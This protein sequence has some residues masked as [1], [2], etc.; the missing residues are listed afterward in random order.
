MPVHNVRAYLRACLDSILGQ[1]F[2]D[3]EIIA[4]DDASPDGSGEI[5]DVY[6][7]MDSRIHVTHLAHN[8]GLGPARDAGVEQAQ[9]SYLLFVDSDDELT[10]GAL[11]AIAERVDETR[12]PDVLI[13]DY[14]RTYWTGR[15]SRNLLAD[16]L[17]NAGDGVFRAE[18]HPELLELLMVVWNKAYKREYVGA[19]GFRFPTGYYEDLPWT[20]PTML[21]AHTIA[22]LDRVCYHYRQRRHGNILRSQNR[23]HFDVFD[24]YDLVLGFLDSHH[25][26]ES[27]RPFLFRRMLD[28]IL[29]IMGSEDRIPAS[30]R[31]EFFDRLAVQYRTHKPPGYQLPGGPR[32]VKLRAV[33]HDDYAMFEAARLGGRIV[34]RGKVRAAKTR[35]ATK[36]GWIASKRKLIRAAY[37]AELRKPVDENLAV[38]AAYWYA[39]YGCNPGAIYEEAKRLAPHIRGVWVVKKSRV[40]V[41]PEGVDYVEVDS[42]AYYRLMA[43]AKYFVN[44]VNFRDNIVKRPGTVHVQ[45]QHGTPLK[46]MG[47]D[48]REFPVGAAGMSF[49]KLLERCDRWDFLVSS[50]R[51]STQVWERSYPCAYITLETGYP[52]NDR[53]VRATAEETAE[54]RRK[55]ELP[56]DKT[57]LLYTPTFRD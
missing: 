9:G 47:L 30:L 4:V 51:F 48:L 25:E 42:P 56:L 12:Q 10:P 41:M 31:R 13:F 38:Y 55:L 20:Y 50:N 15:V 57:V 33:A 21:A 19:H 22:V 11:A 46:K 2:A 44:N 18:D 5:L 3:W 24:Q 34:R 1:S 32:G 27:W 43:R 49:T 26:L 14:A 39:G 16:S 17:A 23:K 6:A 52:R 7:G 54:L 36:L 53:L 28:H 35:R 8:V 45:T 29:T 37:E 40:E